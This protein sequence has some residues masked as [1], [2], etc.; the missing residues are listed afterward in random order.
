[1]FE[2]SWCVCRPSVRSCSSTYNAHSVEFAGHDEDV[3]G[4]PFAF[5]ARRHKVTTSPT[6]IRPEVARLTRE[7]IGSETAGVFSF[8]GLYQ[9]ILAEESGFLD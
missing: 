7:Q 1:M 6:S 3:S 2:Q 8:E 9:Q 4:C 5:A